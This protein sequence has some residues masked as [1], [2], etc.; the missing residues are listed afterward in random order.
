[1]S[2]KMAPFDRPRTTYYQ[3]AVVTIALSCIISEI[4]R[5][6]GPFFYTAA[7]CAPVK[8]FPSEYCHTVCENNFFYIFSR[9]DR[10]LACDRQTDRETDGHLATATHL[11]SDY[12]APTRRSSPTSKL[13]ST[14]LFH[15]RRHPKFQS[16]AQSLAQCIYKG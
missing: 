11:V 7:F 16:V 5:D 1:M 12:T 14:Q 4:K 3:S 10:I 6:I 8:G 15:F 2:L 13:H 9:F